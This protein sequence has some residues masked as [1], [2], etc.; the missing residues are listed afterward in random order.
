MRWQDIVISICQIC[1]VIALMPSITSLNKPH[2]ST[3]VMNF[4]L[5]C[6]IATCLLTLK[7]WFSAGTAFAVAI[8]WLVLAVQKI[9]LDKAK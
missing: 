8:A 3:S 7:L 9:K 5:V 2:A 4:I 6:T 1:F